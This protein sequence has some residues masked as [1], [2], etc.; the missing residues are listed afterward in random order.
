MKRLIVLVGIPGSGKTT[1]AEKLVEKGYL[2]LNADSIRHELYGDAAN[3]GDPEE[4]FAIFFKQLEAALKAEK[5]IVI[6]NTNSNPKQRKPIL[7]MAKAHGYEDIQIWI[8]DVALEICLQRNKGRERVV[9]EEI[10]R[11]VYKTIFGPGRPQRSEGKIVLV[12]PGAN[13]GDFSFISQ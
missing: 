8:M 11:N 9:D 12:R 13:I 4:V 3:Q 7:D 1:L 10:V 2:S 6:D 5:A